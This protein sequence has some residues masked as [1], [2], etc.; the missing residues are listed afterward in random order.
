MSPNDLQAAA[1]QDANEKLRE[2]EARIDA[3][4][5]AYQAAYSALRMLTSN[6]ERLRAL[7]LVRTKLDEASMWMERAQ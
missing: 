4:C 2:L 7:A 1:E 5:D 6:G 3:A